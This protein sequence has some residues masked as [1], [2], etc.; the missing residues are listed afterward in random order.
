M[1]IE[2]RVILR[3]TKECQRLAAKKI[4]ARGKAWNRFFL[5]RLQKETAHT[6]ILNFW[7]PEL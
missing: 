6:L 7:P 2:I 1:K 3:L 5:Q 4:A